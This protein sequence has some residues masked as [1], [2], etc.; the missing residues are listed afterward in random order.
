MSGKLEKLDI[1]EHN[2][3][4]IKNDSLH[5]MNKRNIGM[6]E[7]IPN[8][9]YPNLMDLQHFIYNNHNEFPN[10]QMV[11]PNLDIKDPKDIDFTMYLFKEF[12]DNLNKK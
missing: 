6:Q 4:K 10:F 3:E 1:L 2:R 8:Y 7:P 5:N 9:H 11:G 12:N